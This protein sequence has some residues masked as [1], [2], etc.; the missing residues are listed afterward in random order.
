M[1]ENMDVILQ[2]RWGLFFLLSSVVYSYHFVSIIMGM[3]QYVHWNRF[4]PCNGAVGLV[5]A[6][7][8]LD[9]PIMVVLLFHIVEWVRQTILITVILVGVKWLPA[10][11]FL[12]VNAL[13]G[14]IASMWGI[15]AGFTAG[16]CSE[17]ITL[18]GEKVVPQGGRVLFL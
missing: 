5:E 2:K 1:P 17:E 9:A 13:F 7:A 16:D 12:T 11:H 15:I 3:N 18:D 4:Q 8:V 10:Y 14:L 6:S